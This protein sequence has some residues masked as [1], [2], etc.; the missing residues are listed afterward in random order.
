MGSQSWTR[1]VTGQWQCGLGSPPAGST[2]GVAPGPTTCFKMVGERTSGGYFEFIL[3]QVFYRG[4]NEGSEGLSF[5][6]NATQLVSIE[7]DS[8]TS[9]LLYLEACSPP[10]SPASYC[11]VLWQPLVMGWGG[12]TEQ[13]WLCHPSPSLAE[14]GPLPPDVLP[15]NFAGGWDSKAEFSQFLG[16]LRFLSWWTSVGGLCQQRSV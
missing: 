2:F 11:P 10:S 15:A 1:L 12:R 6:P 4:E 16:D 9:C 5:L 3:S 8:D 7:L 13:L 14:A